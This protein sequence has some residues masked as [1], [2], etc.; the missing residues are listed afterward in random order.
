MAGNNKGG[1]GLALAAAAVAAVAGAYFVYGKMDPKTKKKIKG[2]TLKAKAE[3][4]EQVEKLK[5]VNQETYEAVV[6]KVTAK[7]EKLK[8]VDTTELQKLGK[9]LKKHWRAIQKSLTSKKK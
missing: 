2:W 6:D 3:V 1:K 7:Y 4:L 9:D 5:E 8:E